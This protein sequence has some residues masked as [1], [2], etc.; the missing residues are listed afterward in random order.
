MISIHLKFSKFTVEG[1]EPQ[2][3]LL[4]I[5]A[6]LALTFELRW[7]TKMATQ[8]TTPQTCKQRVIL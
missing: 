2:T 1:I 8:A 5:C 7:T 6:N 4:K 3:E